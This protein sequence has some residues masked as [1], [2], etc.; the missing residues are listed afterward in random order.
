MPLALELFGGFHLFDPG[1]RLVRVP[2]RRARGLIAYLAVAERAVSRLTLAQLLCLD[3]DEQDQRAALRQAVYV[4][5][6]ATAQPDLVVTLED[7]IGLNEALL[8]SDAR[9]F[10]AAIAR[11]DPES[12]S[13][14]VELYRG[15]LLAGERSPSAA[16]EDW[17]AGRRS[18]LLE[19]VLKALLALADGSEA[20]GEHD[21]ALA[22]ARRALTLDPL[23][24][25]ARRQAMRSLAAL[26]QRA[27]ALRQ[28]EIGRQLLAEELQVAPDDETEMLHDAICGREAPANG[29]SALPASI[30]CA[31]AGGPLVP[32]RQNGGTPRAAVAR[33]ALRTSAGER[34]KAGIGRLAWPLAVLL[35]IAGG[36]G[37]WW[38]QRAP[39]SPPAPVAVA[40]APA[41]PVMSAAPRLS[42]VVL[43]FANLSG[44]PDQD[45][46]AAGITDQ[47]TTDLS[48]IDDSFVIARHTAFTYKDKPVNLRELG[49]DLGVRYV[50]EGSVLRAGS[51]VQLDAKL[52]DAATGGSLWAERFEGT[53]DDLLSVP[54]EVTGRIAA[55]L[56]LELIEAEGRRLER[57][58]RNDPDA[59]DDA[60]RGWALLYRAYSRAN[61]QEA[62]ALFERAIATDPNTVS[63]LIGLAFV[64]QGRSDAPAEDRERADALLRR[65]LDLEPNRA[66]AH[67]VL[68]LVRRSKGRLQEAVDAL[69]TAVSLDPNY[70]RGYFELGVTLLCLGRAEE[71]IP[72]AERALRLNPRDPNVG[73]GF[74]L[75]GSAHLL[76]GRP[77]EAIEMLERARVSSPRLWYVRLFLAAAYGLDGRLEEAKQELAE[78]LRLRPEFGSLAVI[79][80][81]VPEIS[82]AGFL[83]RAEQ[84]FDVG[85]HR[86]GMPDL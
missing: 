15:P 56:R 84:T 65:A 7:Q 60:M 33:T 8:E 5:R 76:A 51:Q 53:R 25:D 23:R 71:A 29:P 83:E 4:A 2:D 42:I 17:L 79:R 74:W 13:A 9:R 54:N 31:V 63:A 72:L 24:E 59:L 78:H 12:L 75:I 26:G 22:L 49:R 46:F 20:A 40:G 27:A 34:R 61:H 69:Q 44:D 11:G 45:Y 66:S 18:E 39:P 10:Q 52:I 3:G 58:R 19:Q 55:T 80:A 30:R 36:A 43:P 85:L 57:A 21:R 6:K 73:D 62:R 35:L 86:A 37:V 14:A 1:R 38:L 68:G 77:D 81:R 82:Q 32:D 47:V 67:F 16:F 50:L 70:A 64:L 48:R 41:V 28:Y